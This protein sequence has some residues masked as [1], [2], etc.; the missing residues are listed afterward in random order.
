MSGKTSI[1][2]TD[3]T[4]NPTVGCSMGAPGMSSLCFT[5]HPKNSR[6]DVHR[7]PWHH[8][9]FQA[10]LIDDQVRWKIVSLQRSVKK[11]SKYW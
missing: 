7:C 1:E 9:I 5:D 4:W 8:H 2:W 11:A 6:E 10:Y 3:A